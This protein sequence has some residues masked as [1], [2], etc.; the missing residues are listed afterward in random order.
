MIKDICRRASGK[1][2]SC[3]PLPLRIV[4]ETLDGGRGLRTLT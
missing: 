2:I 4:L 1:F 3:F